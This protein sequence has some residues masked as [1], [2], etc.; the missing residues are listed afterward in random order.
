MFS[1]NTTPLKVYGRF[2]LPALALMTVIWGWLLTLQIEIVA[3]ND[4]WLMD[5]SGE[6]VIAWHTW[7]VTHPPAYPLL[8]LSGN[9]LVRV[10][11]LTGVAPVTAASLVS[12]TFGLLT[13]FCLAWILW[14]VDTTGFAAASGMWLAAF[15]ALIW[16][17]VSVAEVYSLGLCL[18]F[19]SLALALAVGAKPTQ[20]K[21]LWLGVVFGLAI[22]HHRTLL[23]FVPALV[24][25][26]W[27]ARKLG[28]QTW[29]KSGL[30]AA[31]SL[32][33]YL[34]LPIVAWAGSP[35]I[36]GRSPATWEGF[37]DAVFAREYS[38]QLAPSMTL[39]EIASD[40]VGRITAVAEEMTP[41]ATLAGTI[42]LFLGLFT[43]TT[44]RP[45]TA[46][47]LV[48]LGYWL[49]PVGQFLLIGTHLPVMVGATALA[50]AGGAGIAALGS[51]RPRFAWL[52]GVVIAGITL[53]TFITHLPL[54]R[55]S[56]QDPSGRRLLDA[57]AAI[58]ETNPVVL[59]TWSPRYF[60][61]VYGKLITGEI[62]H[63]RLV[64]IRA[65]LKHLP[66]D[67]PSTMYITDDLLYL[68]PL[69]EWAEQLGSPVIL[70]SAGD[71]L[72]MLTSSA[73]LAED[74]PLPETADAPIQVQSAQA[75][76][77]PDGSL[78][79]T[80]EWWAWQKPDQDYHVFVHATDLAQITRPEDIIAQADRQ[81]PVYGFYPTSN[82]VSGQVV[83]DDYRL[84][85]QTDREPSQ[86]F[87]GLYT[88]DAN[89]LFTNYAQTR[90]PVTGH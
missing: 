8:N 63:I 89:G 90:V 46:L 16:L 49:A 5:D 52:G 77:E 47:G 70:E 60:A 72:V 87:V 32:L 39:P 45:A 14:T 54:T 36:Y 53:L 74:M 27:P 42:G 55:L 31:L 65:D 28:W 22:G 30:L 75:W 37:I 71:G 58:T 80:V 20:S 33:I 67:R 25:A 29:A 69:E 86:I 34:Y 51:I 78:R 41:L 56:S 73:R 21:A 85:L 43:P 9:L 35:W 83:R 82:W 38:A 79:L 17:Y 66:D 84:K 76:S 4:A 64:D 88:I 11:V 40:M 3:P 18:G 44:R 6:F 1:L 2:F 15:G 19:A 68:F 59:E 57:T 12:F 13:L 48:F 7:G 10:F 61:L 81:H 26:A 50:G 24:V 23:L 62:S